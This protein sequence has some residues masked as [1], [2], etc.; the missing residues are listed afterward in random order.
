MLAYK[1]KFDLE[2]LELQQSNDIL[3]EMMSNNNKV[4]QSEF[5]APVF[6]V[7]HGKIKRCSDC[8][9]STTQRDRKNESIDEWK[10]TN[11]LV[12]GFFVVV[13][14]GDEE[15]NLRWYILIHRAPSCVE[16]FYV[17]CLN[18]HPF[19]SPRNNNYMYLD[20]HLN[21]AFRCVR[22][23]FICVLFVLGTDA[24]NVFF[25]CCSLTFACERLFNVRQ[26][27]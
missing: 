2:S 8:D 14:K 9:A 13:K 27:R 12:L 7:T 1:K 3:N 23:F 26:T 19:S 5:K 20:G 22:F 4:K 17:W 24:E 16:I 25:S 15:K 11:A 10:T 21:R 6:K 18:V